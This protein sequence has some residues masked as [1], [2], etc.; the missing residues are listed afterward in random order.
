MQRPRLFAFGFA[1]GLMVVG[2]ATAQSTES[3][4]ICLMNPDYVE[5]QLSAA[6]QSG[7]VSL[8]KW[9]R[10]SAGALDLLVYTDGPHGSGRYWTVLVAVVQRGHVEPTGGARV[11]TTTAGW[12]TLLNYADSPL[13][14]LKDF[15][16]DGKVELT[17][18]SSFP[19]P[20]QESSAEFGLVAWVYRLTTPDRLVIDWDLSAQVAGD[21]A[22]AY[23]KPVKG[24]SER[25]R[26]L[27]AAALEAFAAGRCRPAARTDLQYLHPPFPA[28]SRRAAPE[29]EWAEGFFGG[30]QFH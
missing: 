4:Q 24:G 26:A 21:L 8:E 3:S 19:L 9:T 11:E 22:K 17:I 1:A 20:G 15:D 18:W 7:E 14:W 30:E 23:R 6:E 12:R 2:L 13:P 27:S 5:I 25:L 10:G 28:S 29:T 16:R